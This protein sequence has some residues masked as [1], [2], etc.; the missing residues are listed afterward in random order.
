M[1]SHDLG[2]HAR[3]PPLRNEVGDMLP[4]GLARKKNTHSEQP[5]EKGLDKTSE[6]PE[7]NYLL[8]A[9][10]ILACLD[11]HYVLILREEKTQVAR[12]CFFEVFCHK[13]TDFCGSAT[14]AN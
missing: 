11:T 6:S 14:A 4:K 9:A 2:V 13:A 7:G 8:D 5:R 3:H 1:T 10:V 12:L